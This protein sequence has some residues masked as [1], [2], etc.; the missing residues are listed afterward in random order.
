ME[1]TLYYFN[2]YIVPIIITLILLFKTQ[3]GICNFLGRRYF[4]TALLCVALGIFFLII[5][6]V[7]GDTN[8]GL[9]CVWVASF[10]AL[11]CT[12]AACY[13][14]TLYVFCMVAKTEKLRNYSKTMVLLAIPAVLFLILAFTTRW[15]HL[16]FY[17]D[18]EGNY[19]RG[20]LIYAPYILSILYLAGSSLMA[21]RAAGREILKDQKREYRSLIL[22]LVLPIAGLCIQAI[23][24]EIPATIYCAVLALIAIYFNILNGQASVDSLT[25]LNNRGQLR[26]Y[27]QAKCDSGEEDGWALVMLDLDGFKEINDLLG[28]QVGDGALMEMGHILKLTFQKYSAFLC[29]YGGDEFVVVVD[30]EDEAALKVALMELENNI[31]RF[32]ER[33]DGNYYLRYSLGQAFFHPG[34]ATQEELLMKADERMYRAKASHKQQI[35]HT[36]KEAVK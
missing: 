36:V 19:V 2:I 34:V 12:V 31:R 35:A 28:H 20:S 13:F 11:V 26:R 23:H 17:V 1:T 14:W 8:L 18:S 29:R 24:F 30:C 4:S 9:V 7:P 5:S 3:S 15:T 6:W 16:V 22:F 27:L 25:G 10:F 32:N 33:P 21:W